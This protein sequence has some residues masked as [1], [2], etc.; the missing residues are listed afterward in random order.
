MSKF[1]TCDSGRALLTKVVCVSGAHHRVRG[2]GDV[3]LNIV[4][5][6]HRA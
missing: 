3:P 6:V 4:Q 5:E 2:T 1:G